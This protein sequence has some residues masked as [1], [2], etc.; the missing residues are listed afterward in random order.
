[1]VNV[2]G[3]AGTASFTKESTVV[4]CTQDN[5]K[6]Q[7]RSSETCYNMTL[8]KV[9]MS[10]G[11]RFTVCVVYIWMCIVCVCV[12]MCET[13]AGAVGPRRRVRVERR[14]CRGASRR[15]GCRGSGGQGD[16]LHRRCRPSAGA[17]DATGRGQ[18]HAERGIDR[19]RSL[20]HPRPGSA[21]GPG[22]GLRLHV[23]RGVQ[24]RGMQWRQW[25]LCKYTYISTTTPAETVCT[26]LSLSRV[27]FPF[28]FILR[29]LD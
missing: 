11:S 19:S 20:G 23:A 2:C 18:R 7:T 21:G 8:K 24:V 28:H 10:Q 26:A 13:G 14:Q 3:R 29:I 1:M 22:P 17:R 16:C 5:S 6:I 9:T 25:L 27:T 4:Y 15:C 12:F